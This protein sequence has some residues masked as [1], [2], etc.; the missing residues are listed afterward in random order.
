MNMSA[1]AKVTKLAR[2]PGTIYNCA[3]TNDM[4]FPRSTF[5][6]FRPFKL[7]APIIQVWMFEMHSRLVTCLITDLSISERY[8]NSLVYFGGDDT[9]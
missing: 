9:T 2:I 5:N 6:V 4:L 7:R 3:D 8:F 1:N